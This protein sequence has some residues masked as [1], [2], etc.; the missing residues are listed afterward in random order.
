MHSWTPKW[1]KLFKSASGCPCIIA[2]SGLSSNLNCLSLGERPLS[3]FK[4]QL[5]SVAFMALAD[6]NA[7]LQLVGIRTLTVLAAQPGMFQRKR[8][9]RGIVPFL[10]I[11]CLE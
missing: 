3:V 8:K 6:P 4:D 2:E 10:V 5:G 1:I 11:F 7:Q 9:H